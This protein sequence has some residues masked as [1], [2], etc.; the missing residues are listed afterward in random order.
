ME[1]GLEFFRNEYIDIG[2]FAILFSQKRIDLLM[3]WFNYVRRLNYK[4]IE[5][6]RKSKKWE[7]FES[8]K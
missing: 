8:I 5:Y 1:I 6:N 2:T 4:I 3:D 7:A